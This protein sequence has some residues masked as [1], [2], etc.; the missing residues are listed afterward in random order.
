MLV[1][2]L[3]LVAQTLVAAPPV[4]LDSATVLRLLQRSTEFG[5]NSGRSGL[6]I[7]E[8]LIQGEPGNPEGCLVPVTWTE[9]GAFG[10]EEEFGAMASV[11][12]IDTLEPG[13]PILGQDGD[14]A[15]VELMDQEIW[16]EL[17]ADL[18]KLR[19]RTTEA[20][21]LGDLRALLMA[22]EAFA[23]ESGEGVYAGKL[24]CLERPAECL[25]GYSGPGTPLLAE[26]QLAPERGGYR[27]V[28]EGVASPGRKDGLVDAFTWVAV[29]LAG[30]PGQRS[31]CADASGRLCQVKDG[32]EPVTEGGR[33][34][35]SC[36]TLG[37]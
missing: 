27:F 2:A 1:T 3:A 7:G 35:P 28:L 5:P 10:G 8:L 18:A 33:C 37:E 20:S 6:E 21:V 32:S 4:S 36:E 11:E 9:E 30:G 34:A 12:R 13:T 25:E 29:P 23:A 31:F 17:E 16:D 24:S 14:W 22:Q 26:E 15:L 19:A